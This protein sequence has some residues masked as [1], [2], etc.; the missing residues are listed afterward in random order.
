MQVRKADP[1]KLNS[2]VWTQGTTLLVS[3]QTV[4][5]IGDTSLSTIDSIYYINSRICSM[6]LS[7]QAC[8]Q[9]PNNLSPMILVPNATS[10]SL[11]E[12]HCRLSPA[13]SVHVLL[14]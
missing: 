2:Q 7:N 3:F 4:D 14:P 5:Y 6:A 11:G 9:I 1:I 12:M 13:N 10:R 8:Y